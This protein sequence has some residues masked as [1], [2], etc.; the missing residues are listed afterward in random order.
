MEYTMRY[1]HLESAVTECEVAL[2]TAMEAYFADGNAFC[3]HVLH[4]AYVAAS[5]AVNNADERYHTARM[6]DILDDSVDAAVEA[7]ECTARYH[8]TR[9]GQRYG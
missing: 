6:D 2:D 4:S 9:R 5:V 8:A 7:L 3:Y 1:S